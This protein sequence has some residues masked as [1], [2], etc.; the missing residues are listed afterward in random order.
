MIRMLLR[1]AFNMLVLA[2][3]LYCAF[4]VPIGHRT[5]YAHLARIV[6]TREAQELFG[7]VSGLVTDAKVAISSRL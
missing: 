2:A 5:L 1:S 4:F 6:S 3:A 7:A